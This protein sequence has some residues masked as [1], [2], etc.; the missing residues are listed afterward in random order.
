MCSSER[1]RVYRRI[2]KT[3]RE[4]KV[5]PARIFRRRCCLDCTARWRT[6]EMID[7]SDANVGRRHGERWRNPQAAHNA[8]RA[9][10]CPVS[11]PGPPPPPPPRAPGRAENLMRGPHRPGEAPGEAPGDASN[12]EGVAARVPALPRVTE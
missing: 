7:P 11:A 10:G 8:R 2:P 1:I 12:A 4:G 3:G 6:V 9:S 5:H